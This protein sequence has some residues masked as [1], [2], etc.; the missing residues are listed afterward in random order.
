LT[1][2]LNMIIGKWEE[3]FLQAAFAS[4]IGLCDEW[5]FIDTAPGNNPNRGTLNDI[6]YHYQFDDTPGRVKIIDMPR[7]ED[8]DFNFAAARELAR[9][10][11]NSDWVL[12]LDADEVIHERDTPVLLEAVSTEAS[13]IGVKFYHFMV[14]PWLYQYIENKTILFRTKNF[15]WENDVH[16]I[17]RINGNVKYLSTIYF[18][19]GYCRGQEEVFKRWQLYVDIDN[20]PTWYQNT[21]PK[22]ILNDRIPVCKNFKG[23]HPITVQ[24]IL[25]KMFGDVTPFVVKEIPRFSMTENYAGLVLITYNDAE[26]LPTM[27]ES[28]NNTIN[29]PTV[30]YI[31]D[32]GSIDSSTNIINNFMFSDTLNSNILD[33]AIAT[34]I[35]SDFLED[36]SITLNKGFRYLMG[37]QECELIGWVHPDMVFEEGWLSE[38]VAGLEVHPEIGKLC[39]YNTRQPLPETDDLIIGQEQCY[40]IRRGVLYQVG[41][42][43]EKFVGIGGY[44]DWDMNNRIRQEGWK[45][46]ITPKS[47]VF[48][49]GMATRERRDTSA[50]QIHN[51]DVYEKKWGIR[52]SEVFFG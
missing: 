44:E 6:A 36:L 20:R 50:E 15:Y 52:G 34:P 45:V 40:L 33:C 31:V 17:P 12:R 14:Y 3:P 23:S 24:P 18:H 13:A 38:L 9:V 28:L 10:N 1:I 35:H 41:L 49:K 26:N 48:H 32:L 8:K 19:Y 30:L 11:T 43:D 27:L 39:A 25:E 22:E 7:G 46:A 42:F 21:N 47:R 5:V 16:E 2:A 51:A 37:R 29:Y 4:T